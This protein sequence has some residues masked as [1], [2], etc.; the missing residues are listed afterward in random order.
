MK[1]TTR[2]KFDMAAVSVISKQIAPL[3]KEC[4]QV[5]TVV[6]KA[7]AAHAETHFGRFGRDAK[8]VQ[9]FDEIRVGSIVEDNEAGVDI[10]ALVVDF[11]GMRVCVSA[12]SVVSLQDGDIV[13]AL[14][15]I[16]GCQA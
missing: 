3:G 10:N 4:V 13:F 7:I 14:Q 1:C 11:D 8:F 6:L 9:Q 2:D 12:G 16:G 5:V 15:V